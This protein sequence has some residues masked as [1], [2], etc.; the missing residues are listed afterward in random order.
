MWTLTQTDNTLWYYVY[1]NQDKQ[2][3]WTHRKR[4]AD[5]SFEEG[6]ISEKKLKG[7]L[8]S[9]E[10]AAVT[11]KDDCDEDEKMLRDYFQLNVKLSDL[12]RQW[13]AADHHFMQIADIF[14][15]QNLYHSTLLIIQHLMTV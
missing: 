1:K 2:K 13:G 11:Q 8:E 15:G 9:E 7:A 4:T 3:E 6:T 12:Y 5:V 14:P 10:I